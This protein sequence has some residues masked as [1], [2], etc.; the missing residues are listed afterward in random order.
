[1]RVLRADELDRS[2]GELH[3]ARGGTDETGQRARPSAQ[4]GE[5]NSSELG[6]VRD[7]GPQRQRP[8]EMPVSRAFAARA[9]TVP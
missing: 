9:F 3:G 7:V 5:V 4:L 2:P 1:M 6:R 8:L